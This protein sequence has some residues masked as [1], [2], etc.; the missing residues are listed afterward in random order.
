M[1]KEKT[2]NKCLAI[3]SLFAVSMVAFGVFF[4]QLF[5][6]LHL[7]LFIRNRISYWVVLVCACVSTIIVVGLV[8]TRTGFSKKMRALTWLS[9]NAHTIVL[10][11]IVPL[12]FLCV[13]KSDIHLSMDE[14]KEN[15]TIS[16]TMF[17]IIIAIYSVWRILVPKILRKGEPK[18]NSGGSTH[19][20]ELMYKRNEFCEKVSSF[21]VSLY[22]IGVT[23]VVLLIATMSVYMSTKGITLFNMNASRCCFFFCIFT[24]ALLFVDILKSEKAD[25]ESLLSKVRVSKEEIKR[26]TERELNRAVAKKCIKVMDDLDGLSEEEKQRM[27]DALCN[28][29]MID[30]K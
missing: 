3:I 21:Y 13:L 4:W 16:W 10:L 15:I 24:I 29:Y 12:L 25:R 22:L 26:E 2:I 8:I 27:K 6:Q 30:M 23:L 7:F 5:D 14:M 11:Y 9:T 18:F 28:Q 19:P 20:Q 17:G 1:D